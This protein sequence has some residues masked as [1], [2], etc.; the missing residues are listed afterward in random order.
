MVVDMADGPYPDE[1][2]P[3]LLQALFNA[4]Q[5]SDAGQREGAFRI[6]T[7][8]P[9]IIEQQ[10]ESAVLGAFTKGFTDPDVSVRHSTQPA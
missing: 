7:A 2:W 5:S 3:G 6:F 10:H 9:G 1:S 4:S 8:T